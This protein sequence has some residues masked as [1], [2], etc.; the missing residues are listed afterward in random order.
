MGN[1]AVES[2]ARALEGILGASEVTGL[3]RLPGGASRET[4]VFSADGRPLV[5][6]RVRDARAT[7]LGAETRILAAAAAAGVKVP[8]LVVD[9]SRDTALERPYMIVESVPGET[10][11]RRILRDDEFATARA[12]LVREMAEA[13]AATHAVPLD[14]LEGVEETD[15]LRRWSSVLRASGAQRP[16]L[17]LALR[18]LSAHRPASAGRTLVH[19]DFRLGNLMVD[20]GGLVA[21]LDWE[22][23]HIG[24]PMEDL[25]WVGVR[26]WR[27][28]GPGPVAGIGTR[29][30][31]FDAYEAASGV[32]PDPEAV[33]WWEV[34]GTLRWGIICVIQAASHLDGTTRSH[35]LAAIGRRVCENELDLLD[36]LEGRL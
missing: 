19:G 36:L 13:L 11:A 6:Q 7:G 28:G 9:G 16:V 10:I 20:S 25:G 31:L 30:E 1:D 14:A 12:V 18:W 32:R 4:Y 8:R 29:E 33:H 22:L 2:L 27:F 3:R 17:E 23:A 35:E 5:L 24:D 34:F 15:E 21:V 26:A